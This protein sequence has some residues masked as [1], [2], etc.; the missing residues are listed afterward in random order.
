M[1]LLQDIFE[2]FQQ[3]RGLRRHYDLVSHHTRGFF[4]WLLLFL[5]LAPR[6]HITYYQARGLSGHTSP[7]SEY[8]LFILVLRPWT[9]CLLGW[10][11]VF[12]LLSGP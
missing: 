3:A 10:S 6:D 9:S 4:L 11:L 12:L 2:I 7:C 5:T 1:T 8:A